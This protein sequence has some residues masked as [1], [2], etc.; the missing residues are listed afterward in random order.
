MSEQ[1]KFLDW[2]NA[3]RTLGL[4]DIKFYVGEGSSANTAT[5]ESFF[6]EA[7]RI[8]E[9]YDQQKFIAREDVF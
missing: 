7:N 4:V 5:V 9:L 1:D 6:F 2:H 3:Q 8:N